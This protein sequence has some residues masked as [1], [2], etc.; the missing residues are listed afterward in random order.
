M[1]VGTF[2]VMPSCYRLAI[3]Q[4]IDDVVDRLV[5]NGVGWVPTGQ[6]LGISLNALPSGPNILNSAV[7]DV[8]RLS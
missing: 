6:A 1:F 7:A 4:R 3:D 8:A 2:V 5:A